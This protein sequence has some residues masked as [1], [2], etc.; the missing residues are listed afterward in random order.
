MPDALLYELLYAPYFSKTK[1]D[2][3]IVMNPYGV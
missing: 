3:I 2:G 1:S